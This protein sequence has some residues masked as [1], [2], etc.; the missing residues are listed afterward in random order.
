MTEFKPD[1]TAKAIVCGF[2]DGGFHAATDQ[3][4]VI[5]H[6][7]SA[8][9]GCNQVFFPGRNCRIP[10]WVVVVSS[11]NRS[12]EQCAQHGGQRDAAT[13]YHTPARRRAALNR[14]H[15]ETPSTSFCYDLA[16]EECACI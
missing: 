10:G 8:Q 12:R 6:H 15:D 11:D 2:D 16:R 14:S 5:K 1:F 4:A 3:R 9:H 13:A 7:A